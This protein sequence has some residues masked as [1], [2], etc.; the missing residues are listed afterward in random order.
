[1]LGSPAGRRQCEM[2][3]G[4]TVAREAEFTLENS[5][6]YLFTQIVGRRN[7]HLAAALRPF[8]IAVAQWRVLAVLHARPDCTMSGLADLTTV[9]RTTLTR[10]LDRMV[11][12]GLVARRADTQDWR[13]V[14]LR[15]TGGGEALFRQVWPKVAEQNRHAVRGLGAAEL[16]RF[17]ASLHRMVR[18]LDPDY[19]AR[20]AARGTDRPASPRANRRTGRV[21]S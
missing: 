5:V 2:Q 9:D 14:R 6:F 10:T 7:R 18:N 19:D 17:R 15:L 4:G 3:R 21:V 12:E 16:A 13:S 20:N 11:A 8:A 1:M